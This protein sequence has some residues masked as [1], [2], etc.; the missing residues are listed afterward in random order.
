MNTQLALSAQFEPATIISLHHGKPVTT[1]LKVAEAFGK[2]H[3]NVIRKL[4][5]I[6]CS[7][8]FNRLNFEPVEYTDAKGE[9]Q[10]MWEMTKDGFMFLVMGFTGTKAAAIKEAYINAFNWMAEQLITK[11]P[12]PL[13]IDYPASLLISTNPQID[14]TQIQYGKG[15]LLITAG[16]VCGEH[17]SPTRKL[18][19]ELRNAGYD[20]NGCWIEV[21]A[22][23]YHLETLLSQVSDMQ[24]RVE[25]IGSRG[26]RVSIDECAS[27]PLLK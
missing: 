14:R 7:P 9:K 16:M 10:P 17:R 3:K 12:K 15:N 27:L 21:Q 24:R 25:S 22:M 4:Q 1:S 23:K 18:L 5:S 11:T 8:E 26:M 6:E 13:A 2:L 20:I 19:N